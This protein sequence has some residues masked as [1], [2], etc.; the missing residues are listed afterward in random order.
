MIKCNFCEVEK[1]K[2]LFRIKR[3]NPLCLDCFKK[4][5]REKYRLENP[6]IEN[7]CINCGL[8]K[9]K[10]DFVKNTNCCKQ[11]KKEYRI[12]YYNNNKSYFIEYSTEKS[13]TK[14]RK[15]KQ[16]EYQEKNSEKI[17]N[18]QSKYR[19]ENR[20]LI[21][22]KRKS[23]NKIRLLRHKERYENDL[24]Y[25]IKI[26]HRMVLKS[27]IRRIKNGV[28]NNKTSIMLEYSHIELK[29]HLEKLFLEGMTWEN[30]GEWHIDHIIPIT[31]FDPETPCSVVNSLSNLQ[32]LWAIDNIKKSNNYEL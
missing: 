9:D 12:K 20:D 5:K 6:K 15:D 32:P 4:Q 13:K 18:Y 21:R 23:Y 10:E 29:E 8:E 25:K 26:I 1:D 31:A 16:K 27:Y 30:H 3:K 7:K 22:E 28:K 2:D 14:E 24:Q 17:K 11:C 19:E